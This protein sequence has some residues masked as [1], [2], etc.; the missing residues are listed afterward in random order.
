MS[1]AI[2]KNQFGT[3]AGKGDAERP[4]NRAVFRANLEKIKKSGGY[5]KVSSKSGSKTT[6]TYK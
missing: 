3:G 4:V 5:G 1:Q 6:Y 2:P